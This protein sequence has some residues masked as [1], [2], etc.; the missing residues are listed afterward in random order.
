MQL[1]S[2]S[3][4]CLS[5]AGKNTVCESDKGANVSVRHSC[6]LP[7]IAGEIRIGNSGGWDTQLA[8]RIITCQSRFYFADYQV[9]VSRDAVGTHGGHF[10]TR[11]CLLSELG[12]GGISLQRI[13]KPGH[14]WLLLY[15]ES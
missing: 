7:S 3:C 8:C 13:D 15:A 11:I 14:K 12:G 10:C 9:Q 4:E 6:H 1:T 5:K 2:M